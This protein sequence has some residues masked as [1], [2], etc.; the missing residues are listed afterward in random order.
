MQ[1]TILNLISHECQPHSNG[2]LFAVGDVKQSIYRFRLAEPQRF[3]ARAKGF[4]E[5]KQPGKVIDLRANFR[6]RA[7]LIEA[8]NAFFERVMTQES[9]DIEY[10]ATH[11]L[12]P[13][14]EYPLNPHAFAGARGRASSSAR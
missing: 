9:V 12:S 3:L 14:L 1:D 7:K 8:I 4:R 10:D 6:S 13:G 2:N 11:K 5:K